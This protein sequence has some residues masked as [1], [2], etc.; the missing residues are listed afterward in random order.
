VIAELQDQLRIIV[1]RPDRDALRTANFALTNNQLEIIASQKTM[2]Q[3]R[4]YNAA[5]RSTLQN[6]GL[7]PTV[8]YRLKA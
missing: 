4:K 6:H 2:D 8:Q 1:E 5:I 7:S 3:L